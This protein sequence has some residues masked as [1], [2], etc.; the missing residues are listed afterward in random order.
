M[1]F[2]NM[3]CA[4]TGI[5]PLGHFGVNYILK[6]QSIHIKA[7][8]QQISRSDFKP[9]IANMAHNVSQ[10]QGEKK[11]LLEASTY[12]SGPSQIALLH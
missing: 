3:L 4:W 10:W 9:V 6:D 8:Q 12:Q 5:G 1:Q 2:K 7:C 11:P